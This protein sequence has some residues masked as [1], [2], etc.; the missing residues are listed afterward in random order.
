MGANKTNKAKWELI[1]NED[2]HCETD[3]IQSMD[4]LLSV[5]DLISVPSRSYATLK[6]LQTTLSVS[7]LKNVK[8]MQTDIW[9]EHKKAP[10]WKAKK[11]NNVKPPYFGVY[12]RFRNRVFR[13]LISYNSIDLLFERIIYVSEKEST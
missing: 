12:L 10:L 5:G 13:L 6:K 9:F 3:E 1:N 11:A 8:V 4:H 2:T 7:E